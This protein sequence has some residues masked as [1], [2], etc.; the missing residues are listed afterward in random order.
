MEII[1]IANSAHKKF[2]LLLQQEASKP[3]SENVLTHELAIYKSCLH[4]DSDRLK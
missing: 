1:E 4:I 3:Q 2:T